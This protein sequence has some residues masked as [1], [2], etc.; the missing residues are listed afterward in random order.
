MREAQ[1]AGGEEDERRDR[2]ARR[3][4]GKPFRTPGILIESLAAAGFG[5][6]LVL[7]GALADAAPDLG[8]GDP[9]PCGHHLEDTAVMVA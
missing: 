8:F 7:A 9:S 3:G 5:A 1:Q 4:S 2:G 6:A